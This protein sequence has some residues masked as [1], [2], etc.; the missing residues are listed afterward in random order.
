MSPRA[1]NLDS[2][3][4]VAREIILDVKIPE[5][6]DSGSEVRFEDLRDS[7]RSRGRI[8]AEDARVFAPFEPHGQGENRIV[9]GMHDELEHSILGLRHGVRVE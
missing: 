9:R 6:S 7:R 2:G 4:T 1:E 5:D 3:D 8:P